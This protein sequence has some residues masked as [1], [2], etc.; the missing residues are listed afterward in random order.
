MKFTDDY[1]A[2]FKIWALD[3][4][5]KPELP[6]PRMPKFKPQRFSS[7]AEMNAWKEQLILRLASEGVND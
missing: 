5:P 7:H 6:M 3:P 1:D 2:K 4:T